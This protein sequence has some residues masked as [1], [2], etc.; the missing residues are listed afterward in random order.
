[1]KLAMLGISLIAA[2]GN[3]ISIERNW[4]TGERL[5]KPAVMILLLAWLWHNHLLGGGMLW[6]SL[7]ILFSLA[8]DVFL[9]LEGERF[10]L[11]GLVAFLLAH[12]AY[13]IGFNQV[14]PAAN[15][16]LAAIALVILAFAGIL[17]TKL[18]RGLIRQGAT[19]LTLPVAIYTLV[20]TVM[21]ISALF[22]L[23]RPGWADGHAALA[24]AGAL[25]FMASDSLLA[26]NKFVQPIRHGRLLVMV[27]YHLGQFGIILGAAL[28]FAAQ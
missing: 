14:T 17:F 11:P 28:H 7:G 23:A 22:T 25:A 2:V 26:W 16:I 1:M 19:S 4:K 21:V 13:I 3:W 8:G 5:A 12:L 18:R 27:S 6:F 24:L 10:F 15:L 9:M 20:I